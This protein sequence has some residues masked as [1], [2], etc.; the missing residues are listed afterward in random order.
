MPFSVSERESGITFAVQVVPRSRK[1]EVVGL[2]GDALKV[3]VTAPPVDGA[4]NKALCQ[5]LAK[6]LGV[7]KGRVEIVAGASSRHKV[8][9]VTGITA[10]QA[11]E[12][13]LGHR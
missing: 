3:R 6:A 9:A 13:L 7:P 8:V 4:A 11:R 1:N 2:Q 12:R 5:F 10:E